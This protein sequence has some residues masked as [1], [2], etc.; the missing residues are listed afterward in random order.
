[1]L[2]SSYLVLRWL[3]TRTDLIHLQ[4]LGIFFLSSPARILPM[5]KYT[6]MAY[7][8]LYPNNCVYLVLAPTSSTGE[9]LFMC[10][11]VFLCEQITVFGQKWQTKRDLYRI[12][13][14]LK[15]G[16]ESVVFLSLAH[17][18]SRRGGGRKLCWFMFLRLFSWDERTCN[19][20]S[21]TALNVANIV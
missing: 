17:C 20:C 1:M 19:A 11:C 14:C 3:Q 8:Y 7:K 13:E 2:Y 4:H 15:F 10:V 6:V 5:I 16:F 12:H 9:R 18:A 21:N